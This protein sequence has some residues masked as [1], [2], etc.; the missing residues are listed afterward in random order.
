MRT[1]KRISKLYGVIW[2][3]DRLT[4]TIAYLRL[5]PEM[6]LLQIYHCNCQRRLCLTFE[7]LKMCRN[8]I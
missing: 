1:E 5:A 3:S 7:V 8:L 6:K 2:L 4:K